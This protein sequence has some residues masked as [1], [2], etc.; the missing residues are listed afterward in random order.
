MR[1]TLTIG[2]ETDQRL[3]RLA[4]EQNRTYKELVNDALRA[5]LDQLEVCEPAS[6]YQVEAEE[7]GLRPGVD[8]TKLNQAYDELESGSDRS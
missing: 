3:R 7:L 8:R 4:R 1:T 6:R 2:D 5:G